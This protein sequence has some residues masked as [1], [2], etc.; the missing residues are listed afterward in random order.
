MLFMNASCVRFARRFGPRNSYA[1]MRM[2]CWSSRVI[3][4]SC[5]RSSTSLRSPTRT[6]EPV[7]VG[8]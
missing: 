8:R 7:R 2:Y 1:T 6:V 5:S 4:L 3:A